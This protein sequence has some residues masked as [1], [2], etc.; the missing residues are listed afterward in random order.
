MIVDHI[1]AFHRKA[2]LKICLN[3]YS[4]RYQALKVSEFLLPFGSA[5]LDPID[6]EKAGRAY[7]PDDDVERKE[8]DFTS[9]FSLYDPVLHHLAD[10]YKTGQLIRFDFNAPEFAIRS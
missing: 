1:D 8:Q 6:E 5:V 4:L 2:I 7:I 10:K 3:P 9:A